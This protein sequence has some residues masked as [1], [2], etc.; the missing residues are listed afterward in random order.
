MPH[1]FRPP[2]L[3]G[4]LQE[5]GNIIT[6]RQTTP[7]VVKRGNDRL[8][9]AGAGAGGVRRG[10]IAQL[11]AQLL[12]EHARV[13]AQRQ[14]AHKPANINKPAEAA[15][16]H[17]CL[18]ESTAYPKRGTEAC[19][20]SAGVAAIRARQAELT[21]TSET[22][23]NAKQ[24]Y[25]I[26]LQHAAR[27]ATGDDILMGQRGVPGKIRNAVNVAQPVVPLPGRAQVHAGSLHVQWP[28][29]LYREH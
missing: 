23:Q 21:T 24:R 7:Q 6:L 15:L 17:P 20:P 4:L 12:H 13:A 29:I 27:I 25:L 26:P 8:A 22:L 14:P 3:V 1:E 2:H 19:R 5:P 11:A 9:A 18:T 16:A 10:R 28:S